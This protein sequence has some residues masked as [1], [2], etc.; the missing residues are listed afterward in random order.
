MSILASLHVPHL[1]IWYIWGIILFICRC[2]GW[3]YHLDDAG[4]NNLRQVFTYLSKNSICEQRE[5][6][7][8]GHRWQV[9][10]VQVKV[11][12]LL[13]STGESDRRRVT[14][15]EGFLVSIRFSV[16]REKSN[17]EAAFELRGGERARSTSWSIDKCTIAAATR[18]LR[19]YPAPSPTCLFWYWRL[20]DIVVKWIYCQVDHVSRRVEF[21]LRNLN[22]SPIHG[23]EMYEMST[24]SLHPPPF[25]TEGIMT[26]AANIVPNS[27]S[28]APMYPVTVPISVDI[29]HQPPLLGHMAS[30]YPSPQPMYGTV[31]YSQPSMVLM[32][33]MVA[34]L[35]FEDRQIKM[36]YIR[37]VLGILFA[38]IG[39]C[40][41]LVN[42]FNLK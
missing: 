28:L 17:E 6:C 38:Q 35:S 11:R 30:A 1:F 34:A 39:I 36:D 7:G 9:R 14:P 5:W 22:M 37:K 25:S 15:Q 10:R 31:V 33:P 12:H 16:T 21:T 24:V 32:D 42:L 23:H 20:F 3:S 2:K 40:F 4:G 27:T 29:D 13:K 26:G 18:C 8:T 19:F 41:L